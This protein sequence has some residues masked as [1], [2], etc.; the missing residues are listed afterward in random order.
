[1]FFL[2]IFNYFE[3]ECAPQFDKIRDENPGQAFDARKENCEKADNVYKNNNHT[4]LPVSRAIPPFS[5][6]FSVLGSAKNSFGS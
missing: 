4:F 6:V 5:N 3:L 2:F 1:M